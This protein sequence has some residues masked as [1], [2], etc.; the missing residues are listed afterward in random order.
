MEKLLHYNFSWTVSLQK[1]C[2]MLRLEISSRSHSS[3]NLDW[4]KLWTCRETDKYLKVNFV[5][6]PLE[7]SPLPPGKNSGGD[8][9]YARYKSK[10]FRRSQIWILLAYIKI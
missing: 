9:M 10:Y 7:N 8:H 5:A 6:A 3:E 2:E 4:K 1:I